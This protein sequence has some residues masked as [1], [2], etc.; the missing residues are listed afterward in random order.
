MAPPHKHTEEQRQFLDPWLAEFT[1]KQADGKLHLFWPPFYKAWFKK[2]PEEPVLG[3]PLPAGPDARQLTQVELATL[4][5]AILATK[6]RLENWMRYH[7]KRLG[8]ANG[9]TVAPPR[10]AT[11]AAINALFDL[12]VKRCRAHKPIEIFQMRPGNAELIK[13]RLKAAGYDKIKVA[14]DEDEDEDEAGGVARKKAAKSQRMRLRT[15][16]VQELF[17]AVSDEEKKEIDEV[18]AR[19]KA[20]IEA[21]EAQAEALRKAGGTQRTPR[22]YQN[23]VDALAEVYK[24]LHQATYNAAGWVGMTI[25]GGPNPRLPDGE[26]SL[27][28]ICFGESP[29]GNDF[30]DSCADFE[31]NVVEPFELFLRTCFT[32]EQRLARALPREVEVHQPPSSNVRVSCTTDGDTAALQEAA[33]PAAKPKAKPKAKKVKTAKSAPIAPPLSL[34][35]PIPPS[36]PAPVTPTDDTT[37]LASTHLPAHDSALEAGGEADP[38]IFSD[39]DNPF[40]DNG[41]DWHNAA[42]GDTAVGGDTDARNA[43]GGD[44]WPV[45]MSAP[46]SPRAASI[47]AAIERGG[48]PASATMANIDP[49]LRPEA[50]FLPAPPPRPRPRGTYSGVSFKPTNV[51]IFSFPSSRFPPSA[52]SSTPSLWPLSAVSNAF[53]TATPLATRYSTPTSN[54]QTP[55]PPL[56][57]TPTTPPSTQTAPPSTEMR[58]S[59]ATRT[60][61][62]MTDIIRSAPPLPPLMPASATSPPEAQ[63]PAAEKEVVKGKGC[64]PGSRPEVKATTTEKEAVAT[65]GQG[66]KKKAAIAAKAAEKEQAAAGAQKVAEAVKR[67]RGRPKRAVEVALAETTNLPDTANA[68]T[69]ATAE[70]AVIQIPT[71]AEVRRGRAENRSR[72]CNI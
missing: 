34:P 65:K 28:I 58:K 7:G 36:G 50:S 40:G 12:N 18:V 10:G 51:G 55:S 9:T 21:E 16:V 5:A 42:A 15:Q 69:D 56:P 70:G 54:A 68:A 1:V 17:E 41:S 20:E 24:H 31:E 38:G 30:E 35:I 72:S 3:L 53:R 60:A 43:A 59:G 44:V 57:S 64:V 27:K 47:L 29:A 11:G 6:K 2:Y 8:R 13:D 4:G 19:E 46:L 33:K 63:A 22:E 66:T 61:Q 32:A 14:E 62:V 48:L 67:G 25:L 26:L 37:N 49:V 71:M 23:G 39:N 45:G 52:S